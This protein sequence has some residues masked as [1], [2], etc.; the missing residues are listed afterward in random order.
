MSFSGLHISIQLPPYY[1][2]WANLRY[3]GVQG[4]FWLYFWPWPRGACMKWLW[5]LSSAYSHP[6]LK[7]YESLHN[8]HLQP[9]YVDRAY[10]LLPRVSSLQNTKSMWVCSLPYVTLITWAMW[11]EP[12][13]HWVSVRFRTLFATAVSPHND[14]RLCGHLLEQ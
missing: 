8:E 13:S 7:R 4:R 11:G 1:L 14:P 2:R 10:Q 6:K 3:C 5:P 12:P 9:S